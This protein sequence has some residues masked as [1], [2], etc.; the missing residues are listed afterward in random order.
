MRGDAVNAPANFLVAGIGASA[1]GI[2]ALEGFFR[3]IP[4]DAGAAFIIVMH[5]SPDRESLLHE[6]VARFTPLTVKVA[7]DGMDLEPNTVYVMPAHTVLSV[8]AG[9]LLTHE[10]G[11]ER[12]RK[13]IDVFLSTLAVD[14]GE[15]AAGVILSGGD[16]DGTLGLKSIKEH[17]GITLAQVHDGF[18]PRHADMPDAAIFSGIV[19]FALPADQLGET[20]VELARSALMIDRPLDG[21]A[22]GT[23]VEETV[24]AALPTIYAS[25]RTQVGHDFSGYKTRTLVRRVL[26][27]MQILHVSRIDDYLQRLRDDLHEVDALFRDLLINVTNFFRDTEAFEA[28]ASQVIPRL[29]ADRDAEETVRIWIPGCATGEEVYSMAMLVHEHFDTLEVRPAVQIFATDI[30]EHALAVARSG[31]YP[32]PLLES[33]SE[34]RRRRFFTAEGESFVVNKDIR[35][36]CLFSP[37]SILRDPP[38]SR[39]DLVSCRNL[40][41]YFGADAQNQVLPTFHYALRPG[42]FLF[43]GAAENASQF[44]E[45]FAP[46]DK[47]HRIFERRATATISLPVFP[48]PHATRDGKVVSLVPR[49]DALSGLALRQ[50][51]DQQVLERFA[52]AHVVVNRDGDVVYFSSRTGKYLENPAGSPTRQLLTMARRE[53]RLDLRTVFREC[54]DSGRPTRREGLPIDIDEHRIQLVDITV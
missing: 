50:T 6:V 20:I 9:R 39:I 27:R 18:G 16:T 44:A 1:G 7:G 15:R 33:V 21:A 14:M 35:D 52:P 37:H 3:R 45:L 42:G 47:R 36:L 53:L 34:A 40:L 4:S 12:E 24:I 43:L 48:L 25:L 8:H 23:T 30:D 32:E 5:L 41:I 54:V 38:F 10:S 31:R 2:E 28:L 13:P 11:A 46:V 26:R 19:D 17:G 22:D 51:V 29:F 49:R